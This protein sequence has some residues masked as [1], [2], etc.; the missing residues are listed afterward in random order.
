MMDKALY[1]QA[2]EASKGLFNN[3]L[4]LPVA[5]AI[6]ATT[7]SGGTFEISEVREGL[8][9]RAAENQIRKAIERLVSAGAA[10]RLASL[11]PPH[12]DAWERRP[13]PLWTF[14]NDWMGQLSPSTQLEEPT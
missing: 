7:D 14:A 10:K 8:A 9:G 11:G 2:R 1:Q 13:H 3:A 4:V 6:S 12:A 5:V